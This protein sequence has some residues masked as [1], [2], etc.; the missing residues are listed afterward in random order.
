MVW[1]NRVIRVLQTTS[2][3]IKVM[4]LKEYRASAL[5]KFKVMVLIKVALRHN[6]SLTTSRIR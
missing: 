2:K 5:K 1:L 4:A 6:Y 3:K